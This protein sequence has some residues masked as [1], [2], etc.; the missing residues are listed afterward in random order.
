[1]QGIY[2][3]TALMKASFGNLPHVK[4]LLQ[5]GADIMAVCTSVS[6]CV[7]ACIHAMHNIHT[8]M[9]MHIN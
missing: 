8:Y 6:A 4:L 9:G 7:F 5:A 3:N 2:G 1:M